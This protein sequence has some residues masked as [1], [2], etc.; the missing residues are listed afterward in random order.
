MQ[1][2]EWNDIKPK[3]DTNRVTG[4]PGGR[5][6]DVAAGLEKVLYPNMRSPSR[7]ALVQRLKT[8]P[9]KA[10]SARRDKTIKFRMEFCPCDHR[11]SFLHIERRR[12]GWPAI[13]LAGSSSSGDGAVADSIAVSLRA[14]QVE[15]SM[16]ARTKANDTDRLMTLRRPRSSSA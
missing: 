4:K 13:R 8:K 9:Q 3:I 2:C 5:F 7:V 6:L 15:D 14:Q 1:I 12:P 11:R 10:E 16:N